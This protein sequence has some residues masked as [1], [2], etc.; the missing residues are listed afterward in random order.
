MFPVAKR[1]SVRH[2]VLLRTPKHFLLNFLL[3]SEIFSGG[4]HSSEK[5]INGISNKFI[6]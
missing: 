3:K 2:G 5:S 6:A 1:G 4:A